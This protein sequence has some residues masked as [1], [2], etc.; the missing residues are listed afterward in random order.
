MTI[1]SIYDNQSVDGISAYRLFSNTHFPPNFQIQLP[2]NWK[3]NVLPSPYS[4]GILISAQG[5]LEV[6]SRQY[7][8]IHISLEKDLHPTLALDDLVKDSISNKK[9][10][11]SLIIFEKAVIVSELDGREA[12]L[13]CQK[14]LNDP[15]Q[16]DPVAYII[17]WVIFRY[18][19]HIFKITYTSSEKL[20]NT[21]FQA[22]SKAIESFSPI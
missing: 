1:R 7:T 5:P 15:S 3:F 19:L 6:I 18:D 16:H 13:H 17:Q 8:G 14:K 4:E 10:G 12:K 21:Y 2:E 20:F 11:D 22:Y 9:Q